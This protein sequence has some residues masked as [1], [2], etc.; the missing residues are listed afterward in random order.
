MINNGKL[1]LIRYIPIAILAILFFLFSI[2]SYN[3]LS[4]S[5]MIN[6]LEVVT[7]IAVPGFGLTVIMLAGGFDLS[8]VGVIG[9]AAVSGISLINQGYPLLLV[10]VCTLLLSIVLELINSVLIVKFKIHPWLTTIATMLVYLGI[11]RAISKGNYYSTESFFF[12]MIRFSK[13]VGI[14]VS[15]WIMLISW[16]GMVFL[17]KNTTIGKYFYAVGGNEN[18]C[19]KSGINVEIYKII[20]FGMMGIFSWISAILYTSQLSGYPPQS[21]Y[22]NQIEIILAV[23]I[24][25]SLS[26]KSVIN[27]SGTL[28]GAILVA[29]LANGMGLMGISSYWI[30]FIEGLFVIIVI[31]GNSI[32]HGKLIRLE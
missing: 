3:F 32:N 28:A 31:M 24:G 15:I 30:K 16:G 22:I 10:L 27:I 6:I 18:A 8:F 7:F 5:N 19:R 26:K 23:F 21:A 20:S 25:M 11:E 17:T 14:P 4:L 9:I 29:F 2:R 1:L 12:S 13:L